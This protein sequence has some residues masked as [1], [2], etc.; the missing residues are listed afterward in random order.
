[1]KDLRV[2]AVNEAKNLRLPEPNGDGKEVLATLQ[3]I[4]KVGKE[5]ESKNREIERLKQILF[6]KNI[7]VD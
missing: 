4:L 7:E 3:K 6:E 5:L 2:L 1:M